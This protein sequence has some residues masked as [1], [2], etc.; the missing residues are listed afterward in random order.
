M[1]LFYENSNN[2]NKAHRLA[3]ALSIEAT[4]EAENVKKEKIFLHLDDNGLS[5]ESNNLSVK[6]DFSRLKSRI[7]QA[8]LEREVIVKAVRI[9]NLERCQ[10]VIDATA[11]M[12]EDSF[13]LAAAGFDVTLFEYNPVIAALLEDALQRA[14]TDEE[15]SH[16]V[17]RMHLV[18]KDSIESL[19]SGE[20]S[21]D[22]VL[23]D[24]MFPQRQKSGLIKKK[25]QL[26]QLLECPCVGEEALL[27]AAFCAMPDKIVIKRP[28][29]GP[30]LANVR[31]DYSYPGKA[32][33]YDVIRGKK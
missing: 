15:L 25:F 4:F 6:G 33:R 1:I 5:L 31:P 2:D 17:S 32:I 11:G 26:L 24:P 7:K 14:G 9:K 30:F 29:K 8:N 22:V 27:N 16:I 21:A 18:K 12:G 28:E 20:Y 13:L 10:R 23:L 19:N 3:E